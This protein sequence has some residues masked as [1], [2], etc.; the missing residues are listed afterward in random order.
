MPKDRVN[1]LPAKD[2]AIVRKRAAA[3]PAPVELR[4]AVDDAE[5][6]PTSWSAGIHRTKEIHA[7]TVDDL[8]ILG[9]DGA[10]LGCVDA[11]QEGLRSPTTVAGHTAPV[12][13]AV[14]GA[15][16]VETVLLAGGIE[17]PE[18]IVA[19]AVRETQESADFHL[20]DL[21]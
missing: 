11:D 20:S 10:A 9:E 7:V 15:H 13:A 18:R 12:H 17:G 21:R 1:S 8:A 6:G 4:S 3:L 14:V 2:R 19:P 16:P 5:A